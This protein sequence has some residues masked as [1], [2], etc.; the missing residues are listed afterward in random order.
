MAQY[1]I[2]LAHDSFT[3]LGGAERVFLRMAELYPDAP[4]YTLVYDPSILEKIPEQVRNRIV[5]TP[6]Q[7]LYRLYPH[8]QH[9]LP[10]IPW[11][12][13][14]FR[15]PPCQVLLSSSSAFA[16]AFRAP[17]GA[18]HI[19]YCHTPTRFLW[20]DREY[21]VQEV[22]LLLRPF[23]HLFLWWMKYWDTRAAKKIDVFLANSR[24]VE[25][26]I[27]QFY[28]RESTLVYP[29]VDTEFWTPAQ[30]K[31]PVT[32]YFLVAGRLHAHK[33]NDLVIRACNELQ[34]PLHVVGSGRDEE[35]LR[36][37][38]GP[39]VT[40]LGRL[41]DVELREQYRHARAYVYPQVE[42]FGLMPVEAAACGTPTIGVSSGGSLETIIPGETGDWFPVGDYATLLDLLK[43]WDTRIHKQTLLLLHA[44]RFSKA[45]FDTRLQGAVQHVLQ[46][47]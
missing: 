7:S 5:A 17:A 33:H 13:Y 31:Q 25:G 38:A 27:K 41:T 47:I 9:L 11:V 30:T 45:Q 46:N 37:L 26:R 18:V 28:K 43:H 24:A 14:W 34:L 22:P 10:C 29:F 39:T 21:I 1:D 23:A 19:N 15:I 8:F 44:Q 16:K 20:T 12:L 3:Q 2:V 32:D 40:F 6:L 42:D 35:R 4:I 36:A